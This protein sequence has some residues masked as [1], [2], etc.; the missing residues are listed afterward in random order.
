[1]TNMTKGL[2]IGGCMLFAI[3]T[4]ASSRAALGVQSIKSRKTMEQVKKD[5]P[6]YYREHNGDCLRTSFRSIYFMRSVGGFSGK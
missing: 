1:M 4:V 6:N 2:I 5:C 3:G